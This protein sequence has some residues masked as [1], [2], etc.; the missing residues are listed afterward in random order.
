METFDFHVAMYDGKNGCEG[1]PLR[2]TSE[3]DCCLSGVLVEQVILGNK[4][5]R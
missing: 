3:M 5:S 4:N 1:N 2:W